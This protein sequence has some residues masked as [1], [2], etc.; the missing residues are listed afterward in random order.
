MD[1]LIDAISELP[2]TCRAVIKKEG[3][4]IVCVRVLN[5]DERVASLTAFIELAEEAGFI[6]APPKAIIAV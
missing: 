3:G 4:Q 6:V 2:D 1:T 5:D